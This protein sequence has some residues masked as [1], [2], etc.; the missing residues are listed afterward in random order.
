MV[1]LESL[2]DKIHLYAQQYKKEYL[3]LL[4]NIFIPLNPKIVV[5]LGSHAGGSFWGFCEASSGDAILISI[6]R[7]HG[8]SPDKIKKFHKNALTITGDTQDK[9]NLMQVKNIIEDKEIDFLFIDANHTYNGVKKDFEVW[10]PLVKDGGIIALHDI[11]YHLH[12]RDCEVEKFWNELK[13][14]SKYGSW[15][16]EEYHF[17]DNQTNRGI[18]VLQK[19]NYSDKFIFNS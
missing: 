18:G 17:E 12:N 7:N 13:T 3:S 9:N 15:K 10:S 1:N 14:H 19:N 8:G 16:S 6:D 5:E 2:W 11:V 4:E